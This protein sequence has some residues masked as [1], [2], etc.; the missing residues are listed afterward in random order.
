MAAEFIYLATSTECAGPI[1]RPTAIKWLD[2]KKNENENENDEIT[3]FFVLCIL[4]VSYFCVFVC[5][6]L[7]KPN[8]QELSNWL[9]SKAWQI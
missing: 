4:V 8:Q 3:I 1:N 9:A 2:L 7:A 5:G 6:K